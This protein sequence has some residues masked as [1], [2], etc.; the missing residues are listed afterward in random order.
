MFFKFRPTCLKY[1]EDDQRHYDYVKYASIRV[2]F[3]PY[4]PVQGQNRKF[5]S[6]MGKYGS[7]KNNIFYAV[8]IRAFRLWWM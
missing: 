6:Y 5:Y 1:Y 4:F 2:F 7:Q 3:V 8:Y